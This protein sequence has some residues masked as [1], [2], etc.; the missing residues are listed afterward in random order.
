MKLAYKLLQADLA[1]IGYTAADALAMALRLAIGLGRPVV[2][3][4]PT[5]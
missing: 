4:Q 5:D 2:G 3:L 1:E